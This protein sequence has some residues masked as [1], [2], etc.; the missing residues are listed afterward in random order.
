MAERGDPEVLKHVIGF[1]RTE[2]DMTQA[3]LALAARVTQSDISDWELGKS[4]PSE[5]ALRRMAQVADIPWHLVMHLIRF[6]TSVVEAV[7]RGTQ[8]GEAAISLSMLDTVLLAVMPLLVEEEVESIQ[9][10]LGDFLIEAE[11][12][13]TTLEPLPADER[14]C[15]IE[16][17]PVDA[18]RNW[19][20]LAKTVC[21]ASASTAAD[22]AEDALE[23]AR[24]ALLIAER[25][26]G[27]DG[28]MA[29]SHAWGFVGNARRVANDFEGADEA[30][31]LAWKLWPAGAPSA[32][33][34]KWRLFDLEAS[35]RR[36]QRKWSHA[37]E[38]LDKARAASAGDKLASGRILLQKAN[39][40]HQMGDSGDA[41]A[42]LEEAAP[43]VEG[44]GDPHLLFTLRFN[45]TD[46]LARLERF[47]EAAQLL[48]KVEELAARQGL[49]HTR[50][51]WLTAKV[52]AGI[53][54]KEEAMTLLEQ[55]MAVFTELELPYDA[56]LAGLDLSV[57]WLEAGRLAEVRELAEAMTWIFASKKIRREALASLTLF[58][59]AARQEAATV[60]LARQV[61]AEVEKA[62]RSGA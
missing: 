19:A 52:K 27:E 60:E 24:L 28:L 22:S 21:E 58:C 38:R 29:V 40:F 59:E 4:A 23:V 39:V 16:T 47:E 18:C 55:V 25:V 57:L 14:R 6:L 43:L 41:L 9:S 54:Q 30:F 56:A 35:L 36:A 33:F 34:P 15:R 45:K 8:T 62:R 61:I 17:A 48:P 31:A 1:L 10:P 12:I 37:L 7:K 2:A 42:V 50:V 32:L 53:G 5:D 3:E 46:N 51:L 26:L 13:W 20:A 49:E 44:F 11:D